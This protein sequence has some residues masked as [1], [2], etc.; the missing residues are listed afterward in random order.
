M[1]LHPK[2]F[3]AALL[4]AIGVCAW[5]AANILHAD[6]ADKSKT[7]KSVAA[8]RAAFLEAYKVFMHPRCMNCHPAGDRPLQGDDSHVHT[9][10]VQRGLFGRG[11][12]ALRC[13]CCHQ[14]ANLPG[15]NMPP[16]NPM[17]RLP[18]SDTRMVFEGK[19]PHQLALQLKDPKQNGGRTL[20]QILEHV[21]DDRLVLWGWDP[22][23]GRTKPPISHDQFD[24]KMREWIDGGAAAPE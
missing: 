11:L 21:T 2:Q 24:Q 8:S 12:Y 6:E 16:G 23:D 20:K 18:S 1:F 15:E 7:D 3:A 14:D 10:N 9:Q 22:G 17:W 4:I 5:L 13:T 19:T